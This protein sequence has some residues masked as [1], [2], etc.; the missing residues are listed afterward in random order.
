MDEAILFFLFIFFFACL[1]IAGI[2]IYEYS[3]IRKYK[4]KKKIFYVE[5]VQQAKKYLIIFAVIEVLAFSYTTYLSFDLIKKDYVVCEA[6]YV[7]SYKG[8]TAFYSVHFED[9]KKEY[10]LLANRVEKDLLEEGENYIITYG[11]RTTRIVDI[12]VAE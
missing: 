11:K 7:D 10:N 9:G 8:R 3:I 4:H 1:V 12:E 6:E 2:I 5:K